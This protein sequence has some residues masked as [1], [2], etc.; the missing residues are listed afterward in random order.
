MGKF[1]VSK[2]KQEALFFIL[3][4]IAVFLFTLYRQRYFFHDDAFIEL[5]YVRN[6]ILAGDLS[7]N[8]GDRV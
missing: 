4:G 3:A 1:R 7:W 5:R 8:P 6:F 2:E